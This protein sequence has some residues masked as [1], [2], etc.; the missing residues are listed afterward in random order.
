MKRFFVL[1]TLSGYA[2]LVAQTP[3]SEEI[4]QAARPMLAEDANPA[5]RQLG[6]GL[7]REAAN[8]GHPKAQSVTGFQLA[9][10]DILPKDLPTAIWYLRE[11][12]IAG[13][14]FASRNLRAITE[15]RAL[16][17]LTSWRFSKPWRHS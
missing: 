16:N 11:A 15:G 9:Q 8:Q 13:D 6:L 10:G 17:L 12:A 7:M 5:S 4:F 14:A 1:V 3:E 2:A